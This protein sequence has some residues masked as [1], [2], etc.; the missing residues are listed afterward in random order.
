MC[1]KLVVLDHDG[2]RRSMYGHLEQIKVEPGQI[3]EQGQRIGTVGGKP[4]LP[5]SPHL[6]LELRLEG[7]A[8][9]PAPYLPS[10]A[11]DVTDSKL[12]GHR[13]ND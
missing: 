7:T 3:V 6:H 1:G 8:V 5:V 2:H 11:E 9:D 12:T 4:A 10:P 13:R